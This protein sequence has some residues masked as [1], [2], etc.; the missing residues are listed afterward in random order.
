[1][2]SKERERVVVPPKL[3]NRGPCKPCSFLCC[4]VKV[5]AV[6]SPKIQAFMRLSDL[7]RMCLPFVARDKCAVGSIPSFRMA[8]SFSEGVVQLARHW[9]HLFPSVTS[10]SLRAPA[11]LPQNN[12]AMEH[13]QRPAHSSYT[14]LLCGSLV[15]ICCWNLREL[16][17]LPKRVLVARNLLCI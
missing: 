4:K 1:M 14:K 17:L 5:E 11:A 12:K 16:A 2:Q 15:G 8:G 9:P 10:Y 6:T 3:R 13:Q 7:S